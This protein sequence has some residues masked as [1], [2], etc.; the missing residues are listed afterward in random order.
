Q[1]RI[2]GKER[3][4][5]QARLRIPIFIKLTAL[6]IILIFLVVFTISFSIL[7][8]QKKQFIGQLINLGESTVHIA[9]S[10]APDKLLGGEDLALFQLV[11]DIAQNDQVMYALITDKKDIIRAHSTIEEV[12]K[13]YSPPKNIIFVKETNNVK[14]S[15]FV[16]GGEEILFFETP[17][18][19][20]KFNLGKVFLAISQKKILQNIHNAKIFIM[21]LTVIIII[22]G[23]LLSLGISRYFS[24]P[25]MNL[26]EST[27]A[28]GRGDF[29]HRI[30]IKRNDEL[31]DLGLAFNKMAEDLALK[32]KIRDSFGR[33]VAPE[34]VNLI[35]ANPDNL[36]MKGSEVEATV[37]FVDIRGFT[38][39]SEN[40]EPENI[41]EMLNDYF[42]RVTDVV[43]KHGGHINK[44][45]GD[46]AMAV[47]GTPVPNPQHAE[48][49]VRAA[50]DIQEEIAR[51]DQ[52]KKMKDVTIQVGI[53]INSG[54]M[55]AG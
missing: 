3:R 51:L 45:V 48:A 8:R 44:F 6:S 49:A 14:V 34:I 11:N 36:W 17:I 43:I 22:L 20:Q 5:A 24:T 19:Y 55:V 7:N 10:N 31:G 41:V 1:E 9:A 37:L 27:E 52:E 47:F 32:E 35:L 26:R 46:E 2:D 21:I 18:T 30:R 39:L 29:D 40:K 53:G 38:T 12:N 42:T 54:V 16:H 23:I 15:F 33:Y 4:S 28:L 25:I 13:S 50:L